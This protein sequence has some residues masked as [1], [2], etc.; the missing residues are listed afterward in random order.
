MNEQND[1]RLHEWVRK[2]METYRP[3]Y[4]PA[5]WSRM[6]QK[7]HRRP[8]WRS[9]IA[10]VIYIGLIG[11]AGWLFLISQPMKNPAILVRNKK[12]VAPPPPKRIA[13]YPKTPTQLS[14]ANPVRKNTNLYTAKTKQTGRT[15][16]T[17]RLSIELNRQPE[18]V[19]QFTLLPTN[20]VSHIQR[21]EPVAFST[22]E[23]VITRQLLTGNFGNDSTTYQTLSR[24]IK[25]W[26]DAVIVCDLTTSMYPYTTQLVTWFEKQARNPAVKGLVFF[27]DCDSLGQETRPEGPPGQMFVTR[28]WSSATVLPIVLNAARNT[29]R[30]KDDAE[31]SVEALLFAQ[32][33]FPDAKHLI[34]VADNLS[35]VKDLKLLAG[36]KKPVHVVLCGTTGSTTEIPFQ[37]DYYKVAS[38]TNGSLHTLEDDLN[39]AALSRKTTLKVGPNYY[40]YNAQKK[41]F[42]LTPFEHRPRRFLNTFWF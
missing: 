6:Q 18:P 7:L 9:G 5:D 16:S 1:K 4:T 23:S 33:Q 34:L 40:R 29:V 42:K 31:N 12:Q 24:N 20:L 13:T 14:V 37:P 8:W 25:Q 17:D 22:E 36:V 38:Q 26:P 41:R 39:P 35:S 3:P 32:K 15:N 11:L 28:E 27:T 2:E 21:K 10:G 19:T 30:N